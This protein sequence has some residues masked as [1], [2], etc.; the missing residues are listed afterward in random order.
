MKEVA[1]S[2]FKNLY[3][4]PDTEP[5]DSNSYPIS[6]ILALVNDEDNWMLNMPVS[7]SE[8]KKAIFNMDPDKAPGPDGFTARFYTS[9]WDIIKKDLYRMVMKSQ[10]CTK[11]G[12]STNSSFLA[13]IPKEKGAK[14]FNRFRP[15]SLCNTGYKIITK[16]MANRLKRICRN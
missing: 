1:H 14:N 12:G 8:I 15:I 11:L 3:S 7:I 10:N 13:L 2:F 4:A 9:C 16:I 6:E 5:M